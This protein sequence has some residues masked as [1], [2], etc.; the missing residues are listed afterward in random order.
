M[1]C[2]HHA[3]TSWL[4]TNQ[5]DAVLAFDH[6]RSTQLK[7]LVL[8][9]LRNVTITHQVLW[10]RAEAN[11]T[12]GVDFMFAPSY[13]YTSV[14]LGFLRTLQTHQNKASTTH[15][16]N[17]CYFFSLLDY[18]HLPPPSPTGHFTVHAINM[19]GLSTCFRNTKQSQ[20]T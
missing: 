17:C 18:Y 6:S 1:P 2:R 19:G 12:G 9:E 13:L 5:C 10:D 20:Q 3:L 8:T 4:Y 16:H 14:Q 11:D 7:L 15:E